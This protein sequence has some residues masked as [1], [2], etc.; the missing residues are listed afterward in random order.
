MLDGI[1]E[2]QWRPQAREFLTRA[3]TD[4]DE[5]AT[6]IDR[7]L[8][9]APARAADE[10]AVTIVD[11]WS[12]REPPLLALRASRGVRVD[13][14]VDAIVDEA[15]ITQSK[16]AKVKRYYQELEGGLLDPR[17]VSQRVWTAVRRLVGSEA[18]RAAAWRSSFDPLVPGAAYFRAEASPLAHGVLVKEAAEPEERDE[19]DELFAAG[20]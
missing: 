19:V 3:G 17:G 5:L 12:K 6:M 18:E 4:A 11:A 20:Q 10:A 13:D 14:V 1:A 16:S 8:A 2:L 7:F 15:D 9:A